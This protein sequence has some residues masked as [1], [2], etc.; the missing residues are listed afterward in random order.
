MPAP[1]RTPLLLLI[2]LLLIVIGPTQSRAAQRA[3]GASG[4]RGAATVAGSGPRA[5]QPR[6]SMAAADYA[7]HRVDYRVVGAYVQRSTDGGRHWALA[8]DPGGHPRLRDRSCHPA[9]YQ[10]VEN[11]RVAGLFPNSL[12]VASRGAP[13]SPPRD[14]SGLGCDAATGGL[15]VLRPNGRGGLRDTAALASGLPY[16]QAQTQAQTGATSRTGKPGGLPAVSRSQVKSAPRTYDL[17]DIVTDPT[18][19]AVLYAEADGAT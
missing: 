16:T 19:P 11:L 12:L 8:L 9:R 1:R 14:S 2:A 17:L 6:V 18:N 7:N 4:G 10:T 13:G 3:R 5:A 15:F